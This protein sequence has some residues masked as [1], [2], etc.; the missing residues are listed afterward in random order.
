MFHAVLCRDRTADRRE[1]RAQNDAVADCAQPHIAKDKSERAIGVAGRLVH[2]CSAF[3]LCPDCRALQSAPFPFASTPQTRLSGTR[4]AIKNRAAAQWFRAS[5]KICFLVEFDRFMRHGERPGRRVGDGGFPHSIEEA[6]CMRIAQIAPL[7]E[8][9]PP[10]LYGGTERVVHWLDRGTGRAR[11]RRDAVR[12]RR[13]EYV[14][15]ARS[16]SGRARCVSTVR[17]AMRTHCTWRC[18]SMCGGRRMN[19]TSCTSIS[20]IIRSRCS[21]ASATPFVTTLHGRL[22][23]PEHQPVFDTFSSAP[24][25]S[26]SNSQR[27]PLPQA[28]WVK[29]IHH[30]L[31]EKLLMPHAGQAVLLRVSRTH[32]AGEARRPRDPDRRALRHSAED[33]REGRPRRPGLLRGG[34][35][36]AVERRR[37]SS[38]SARSATTRNPRS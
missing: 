33:R 22:D 10:K 27:R 25:V 11:S 23:L 7:T 29:T 20:T 14:S 2:R 28:R 19:S 3:L 18:W 9:I 26:I 6:P 37:M 32:R 1:H 8:A 13:L 12:Q 17:C 4:T 35:P 21:R 5:R 36:P 38:T 24:V 15:K 34:N 16:V 31:P 30:G